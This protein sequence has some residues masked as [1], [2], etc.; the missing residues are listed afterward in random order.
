MTKNPLTVINGEGQKE[1]PPPDP[2]LN[3]TWI[4][5]CDEHDTHGNADTEH[6]AVYMGCAHSN[7]WRWISEPVGDPEDLDPKDLEG[8]EF[9]VMEQSKWSHD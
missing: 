5:Y 1:P 6:E 9:V 3:D 4:W 2:P 8:C 7:Y